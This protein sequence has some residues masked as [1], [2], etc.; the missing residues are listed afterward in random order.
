MPS[1][2]DIYRSSDTLAAADLPAGVH[3]PVV[4]EAVRAVAFDDGNKLELRFRGKRKVLMANKTNAM[5]IADQHGDDFDT[6]PGKAIF[7]ERDTTEFKGQLVD[8]VRVVRQ[9][10]AR[11]AS[12]IQPPAARSSAPDGY[13][14]VPVGV[15]ATQGER[16]RDHYRDNAD[17]ILF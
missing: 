4:I 17:D 13:A 1:I 11:P 12:Q 3:V 5:R 9:P 6:W 8:C 7:L 14:P 16:A 15:P 10:I 2:R